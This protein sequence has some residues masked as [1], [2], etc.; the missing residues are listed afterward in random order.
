MRKART[1][2][3]L[4]DRLWHALFELMKE[5]SYSSIS[6][7]EITEHA[8]VGR[9][10]YYRH[11]TSKDDLIIFAFRRIFTPPVIC[12]EDRAHFNELPR[13]KAREVAREFTTKYFRTLAEYQEELTL[14]YEQELDYLL[15]ASLY[16]TATEDDT[17]AHASGLHNTDGEHVGEGE[18]VAG[19]EPVGE[20]EPGPDGGHVGEEEAGAGGEP[21]GDERPSAGRSRLGNERPNPSGQ[22]MAGHH[23]RSRATLPYMRAIHAASTFAI[24]DQW[25]ISHFRNSPEEMANILTEIIFPLHEGE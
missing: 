9:A 16:R 21:V 3:N 2:E 5:K 8:D 14:I 24:I 11:F 13:E 10:T 18:P 17:F 1:T 22:H 4:K 23:K 12:P 19:G 6:I 15:F 25:I 20:K 7:S